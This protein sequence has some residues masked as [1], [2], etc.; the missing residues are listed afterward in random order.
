M[1]H[2]DIDTPH[3]VAVSQNDTTESEVTFLCFHCI[4]VLHVSP[5]KLTQT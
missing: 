4:Q 3:T 2:Y 5:F 1:I